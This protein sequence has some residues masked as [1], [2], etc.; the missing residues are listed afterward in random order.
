MVDT[1]IQLHH[2]MHLS[3]A[4]VR[5]GTE[6]LRQEGRDIMKP[7]E[8]IPELTADQMKLAYSVIPQDYW[9]LQCWTCREEG[10]N[11][12]TC[13]YLTEPQRMYFAYK[14]YRYQ[15][16]QNP[17]MKSWYAQ[18]MQAYQNRGP[19]TRPAPAA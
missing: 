16:D 19:R 11:T 1:A 7:R 4:D 3:A 10:H 14:Y 15:V 9:A 6:G 8:E 5:E 18:K 12:F 2:I 17:H 13:P